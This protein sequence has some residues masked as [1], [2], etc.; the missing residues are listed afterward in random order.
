MWATLKTRLK[1][2]NQ[3]IKNPLKAEI[4]APFRGLPLLDS[5]HCRH[6]D[7]CVKVCAAGAIQSLPL[8][9]DMGKCVFCGDCAAACP[10]NIIKFS[11]FHK[12]AATE[13]DKLNITGNIIPK[14]FPRSA[15][16]VKKEIKSI[17]GKS[18]KLRSVSAGGC[19][20]CEMELNACFNINFDLARYGIEI[21][22]SPRHA[23]GIVITGPISGNM[24]GAVEK[25]LSAIPE[26]VII[27]AMGTCAISGGIF[28]DSDSVNRSFF[29]KHRVDL[30]IPGCPVHPLNFIAG[31]LSFL[32]NRKAQ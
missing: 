20:G 30:F 11:N 1:Q 14:D 13:R 3:C 24:A 31:I 10:N 9:I 17:F 6:C 26:P 21:A 25:T 32:G 15:I 28:K 19:N 7:R 8:T 12:L 29:E 22:A 27:I 23:D 2:T 16:S 4:P 18:L 5:E